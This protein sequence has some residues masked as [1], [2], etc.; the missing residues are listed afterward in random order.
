MA[1]TDV[2]RTP[3]QRVRVC[4]FHAAG[5]GRGAPGGAGCGDQLRLVPVMFELGERQDT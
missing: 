1:E 5:T 4:E 2:I 3:D